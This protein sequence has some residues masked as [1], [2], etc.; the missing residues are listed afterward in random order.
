VRE[1]WLDSATY[2]PAARRAWLALVERLDADGSIRDV[3]ESTNKGTTRSYYLGRARIT[4]DLHGEAP[5]LWCAAEL[6]RGEFT[7]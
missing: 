7:R 4:G 1:G 3:C 2:A 6:L 5:L